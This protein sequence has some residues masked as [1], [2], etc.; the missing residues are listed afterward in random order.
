MH[1]Y[2]TG[3]HTAATKGQGRLA[4]AFTPAQNSVG[5]SEKGGKIIKKNLV[6]T[7]F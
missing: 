6:R 1:S 7:L 2:I 3:T 4:A 5:G